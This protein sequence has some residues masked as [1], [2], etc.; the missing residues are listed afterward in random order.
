[1]TWRQTWLIDPDAPQRLGFIDHTYRVWQLIPDVEAVP[2]I[3]HIRTVGRY[4]QAPP[5]TRRA[6]LR[7]RSVPSPAGPSHRPVPSRLVPSRPVPSPAG[8][9]RPQSA[10]SQPARTQLAPAGPGRPG[11]LPSLGQTCTSC[12]WKRERGRQKREGG[13]EGGRWR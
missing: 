10:R 2:H 13:R 6:A 9:S 8:P 12:G 5:L 4:I 1:M 11:P 7:A 3:D